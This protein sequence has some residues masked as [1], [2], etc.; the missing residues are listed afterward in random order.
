MSDIYFNLSELLNSLTDKEGE[1]P[2][3]NNKAGVSVIIPDPDT[4][5]YTFVEDKYG[6]DKKSTSSKI[7]KDVQATRK[8]LESLLLGENLTEQYFKPEMVRLPPPLH[9]AEDELAWLF[10]SELDDFKMVWDPTVSSR[11]SGVS[12]AKT[13]MSRAFESTLTVDQQKTLLQEIEKDHTLIY[14]VGLTPAKLPELVENNPL[15]AIEVL[16]TLMPSNQISEYLSVLVNMEMSVHSM[17]VV[18]R[19]TTVVELPPEFVHLYITNCIQTCERIKDK[20]M[21]NRLVRLACV[22]LQSLIRNKIIK[23]QDVFLE[24]QAFCIEFSKIREAAALFR[25]LKQLD[26][27]EQENSPPSTTT[28]NSSSSFNIVTTSNSNNN[29]GTS[30]QSSSPSSSQQQSPQA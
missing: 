20:C 15:I 18:N 1:I 13:L 5:N 12:E 24:V 30:S 28:T 26:L 27:C 3:T 25:L 9:V 14:H 23:I 2:F 21:Q 8:V 17:E 16:L 22:F 11:V 6:G 7:E 19:L 10:P 29:T 4:Q